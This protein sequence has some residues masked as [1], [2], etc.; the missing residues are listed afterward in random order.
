MFAPTMMV[1]A[2]VRATLSLARLNECTAHNSM[3][4][5]SVPSNIKHS[6]LGGSPIQVACDTIMLV[7]ILL[8]GGISVSQRLIF[9]SHSDIS[10]SSLLKTFRLYLVRHRQ[11]KSIIVSSLLQVAILGMSLSMYISYLGLTLL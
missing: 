11:L 5:D 1:L 10:D 9:G 6:L 7:Q 3:A 4:E 2:M 8:A